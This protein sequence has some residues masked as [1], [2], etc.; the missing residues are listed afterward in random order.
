VARSIIV[1]EVCLAMPTVSRSQRPYSPLRRSL[2]GHFFSRG[3]WN[4][5]QQ[6]LA[7]SIGQRLSNFRA[8]NG[9]AFARG[10]T[11]I[12]NQRL[13]QAPPRLLTQPPAFAWGGNDPEHADSEIM[14]LLKID[15]AR[16]V[17]VVVRHQRRQRSWM[18]LRGPVGPAQS[19]SQ[20]D[21]RV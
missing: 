6:E 11:P 12:A 1:S 16:T 18:R 15:S 2:R 17:A 7:P 20:S 21:I 4:E 5:F 8:T 9:I 3:N 13:T 10:V 14:Q 19:N